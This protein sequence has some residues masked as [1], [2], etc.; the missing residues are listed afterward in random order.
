MTIAYVDT[1]GG[2]SEEML[3]GAVVDA[4][5]PIGDL[6]VALARLPLR[7]FRIEIAPSLPD[8]LA[9]IRLVISLDDPQEPDRHLAE[10]LDAIERAELPGEV[11]QAARRTFER[12]ARVAAVVRHVAPPSLHLREE[13]GRTAIIGVVGFLLGLHIL[14]ARR[15]YASAL[16]ITSGLMW[17][18]EGDRPVLTP[19]TLALLAEVGATV[20]PFGAE[21]P[22]HS[23]SLSPPLAAMLAEIAAFEPPPMR[24]RTVGTGLGSSASKL[25]NQARLWLG[26]PLAASTH[27]E[28]I[29]VI[30]TNLDS[31]TAEHLG[32]AMERLFEAGAL[33]VTFSPLQMKKNRPGTLLTALA[34]PELARRV[35][36]TM[37]IETNTLGVRIQPVSRV[38]AER[39]EEIV[40]TPY[41]RVRLKVKYVGERRIPAPEYEDCAALARQHGIPIAEVYRAALLAWSEPPVV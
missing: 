17:T 1:F 32:F 20:I 40:T 18:A 14:D 31:M 12:L 29:V 28:Q 33:D 41:G 36:E 10:V 27:D 15:C 34:T 30:E 38:V 19:L 2:C 11:S 39:H 5:V 25:P 26:E 23:E 13:Y 21:S 35:A 4:G 9:G 3:L 7:G 6:R 22:L 24:L 37:L 16:R 8:D